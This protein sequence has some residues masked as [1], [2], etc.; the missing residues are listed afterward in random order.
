MKNVRWIPV[1]LAT[2][3]FGIGQSPS[4]EARIAV[5]SNFTD[6]IT[7]IAERF[8]EKTGRVVTLIFG[9]SGNHYAQIKN[10]APFDAFFSADVERPEFLEREGIAMLDSR[11]TYAIGKL[12]LWSPR[13]GY[14]DSAGK[15]LESGTFHHLAVANPR[16][17]PYGEAAQQVLTSKKQWDSLQ[18]RIV[19]GEN[20]TQTY[21]F[22]QSGNAELGFVAYAQVK[23][24][25]RPMEG[26][27]WVVPQSL[28]SPIEQ[29]AVLL[30]DNETARMFVAFLRSNEALQIIHDHGYDTR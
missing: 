10:G 24:P 26:S 4:Q 17:A 7:H 28:Y 29:Q 13:E 19:L 22:V 1:L 25:G 21:Q 14:V 15:V 3:L 9:S 27:L 5:A 16:L 12:V 20:I 30:R 11:F 8:K 6:T 18:D 2:V 23:R